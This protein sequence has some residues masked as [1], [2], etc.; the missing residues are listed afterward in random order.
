MKLLALDVETDGTK[1]EYALQPWHVRDGKSWVNTLAVAGYSYPSPHVW[2]QP[3]VDTLR[4]LLQWCVDED[5]TIVCWNAVFDIGWLIAM[6]L[7]DLVLANRWLDG[8]LAYK[9]L[10]NAPRFVVG[11]VQEFGLKAAVAAR[12][13]EHAGYG[14]GQ[15]FTTPTTE[16]EWVA[17]ET[18]NKLDAR[19]T[20]MLTIESLRALTPAQRRALLIEAACLPM[21]AGANCDGIHANR[22]AAVALSAEL[23]YTERATLAELQLTAG[24]DVTPAVLAS[25]K[26]LRELMFEKWGLH[27][28]KLTDTGELSTD[29]EA[30]DELSVQDP[31]ADVI[32][33][34]REAVGN[35]T[36][37]ADGTVTSL[38]YNGDGVVRPQA[39]IAST[40]TA[41]LT[42]SSKQGKGKT[43]VPVGVALHQWKRD[44]AFR[45][46]IEAPPGYDLLEFDFAG[47]EFRWMA[48]LSNDHTMLGLCAPG[49]DAHGY[50][51]ASIAR[52]E[53]RELVTAV[54]KG[55]REAKAR[56]QL[57][58]VANLGLGY[59]TGAKKLRVVAK[60]QHN[61]TMTL[62]EATDIWK[63]YRRTYPGVPEY[64]RRQIYLGRSQGYVETVAGRRIHLGEAPLPKAPL[65]WAF[66]STT[67]NAPI[68][69]TG[70][71]QKYLAMAVLRDLLPEY[72][73]RFYFDLHDGL[74]VVVP[75]RKS[76]AAAH[77]I[78]AVLSDLPYRQAWG[79]DLPIAFPVD[80]KLGPSWGA[81]KEVI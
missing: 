23:G 18:Y 44:P 11:A 55:D 56:R 49:E 29:K 21:A 78:K 74:F 22:E 58:K 68:Q 32:R 19:F 57:G 3:S 39:R 17:L 20:H 64:W 67:I 12:W 5:V 38:D 50:M 43:E 28:V 13:P 69:G 2:R 80:A 16:E 61:L 25:P 46:L 41:R 66:D 1:P 45:A 10:H 40:Y 34:Y 70:A 75:H 7:E 24:E 31:R 35:K 48:V 9:A 47:Q 8:M 77:K 27:G 63:T 65:E 37:F 26:Q 33:R 15:S 71:E 51:G 59:R 36:K 72:G 73:G 6:G 60:V 79:V 42:F 81:L 53:Y 14:D 52:R 76:E 30:L 62:I 54:S 4:A